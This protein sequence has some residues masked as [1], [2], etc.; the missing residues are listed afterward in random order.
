VTRFKLAL[1][2]PHAPQGEIPWAWTELLL[3]RDVYHCRPSE[4][5]D[6]EWATVSTHLALLEAKAEIDAQPGERA[7]APAR[8]PKSPF[9]GKPLREG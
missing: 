2:M 8:A 7:S 1:V 9:G 6:E 3:C 4:L 5:Y